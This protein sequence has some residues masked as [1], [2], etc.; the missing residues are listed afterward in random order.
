MGVIS[1][2]SRIKDSV[3]VQNHKWKYKLG[4]EQHYAVFHLT[5]WMITASLS[6]SKQTVVYSYTY[7]HCTYILLH[8]RSTVLW[9]RAGKYYRILWAT[10]WNRI[11]N[12]HWGNPMTKK[13]LDRKIRNDLTRDWT[14]QHDAEGSEIEFR[15]DN[16]KDGFSLQINSKRLLNLFSVV[17]KIHNTLFFLIWF[18]VQTVYYN[19]HM[20]WGIFPSTSV[21]FVSNNNGEWR[22][23]ITASLK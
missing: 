11:Q 1:V 5:F 8:M 9:V 13:V 7:V 21:V 12:S 23:I 15:T 17:T 4:D 22:R 2:I 19:I 3:I 6:S 18:T 14:I 10:Q 16:Q 20:S